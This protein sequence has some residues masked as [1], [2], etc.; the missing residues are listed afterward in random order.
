MSTFRP[1]THRGGGAAERL[2]VK[3]T[4]LE[5]GWP[6]RRQSQESRVVEAVDSLEVMT[7]DR[8]W[9]YAGRVNRRDIASS[10]C[11]R[12]FLEV[13][14][15]LGRGGRRRDEHEGSPIRELR[16]QRFHD[17]LSRGATEW[18]AIIHRTWR[19]SESVRNLCLNDRPA[20]A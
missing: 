7:I 11:E 2:G 19:A 5:S 14:R 18:I 4:T 12:V 8:F 16:E 9:G 17:V 3:P 10:R 6:V 13:I 15:S 1:S 20:L